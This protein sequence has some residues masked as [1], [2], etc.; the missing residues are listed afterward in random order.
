[1][2]TISDGSDDLVVSLGRAVAYCTV[3]LGQ[4]TSIIM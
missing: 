4:G 3:S 1:M 2:C